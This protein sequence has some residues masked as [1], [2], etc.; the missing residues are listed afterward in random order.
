MALYSISSPKYKKY[1]KRR[2]ILSIAASIYAL[3]PAWF[4]GKNPII[5]GDDEIEPFEN[6]DS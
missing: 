1:L 5:S 4:R 2:D 3:D 6:I